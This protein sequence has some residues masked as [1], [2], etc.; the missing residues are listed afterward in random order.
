LILDHDTRGPEFDQV[1]LQLTW[2]TVTYAR[3][4]QGEG[5]LAAG[6]NLEMEKKIQCR[7]DISFQ[8]QHWAY[9]GNFS[10]IQSQIG[11]TYTSEEGCH[12]PISKLSLYP[13]RYA[14]EGISDA[15]KARGKMFWKCRQRR[16]VEYSGIDMELNYHQVQIPVHLYVLS[17]SLT[18]N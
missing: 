12:F 1:R 15:I 9:D 7:V 16:Y 6:V 13:L 17:P 10:C 11:V 8:S 4:K 14:K 3:Y 5:L 18:H 2:P